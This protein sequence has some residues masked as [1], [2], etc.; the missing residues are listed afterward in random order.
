[1]EL[2]VTEPVDKDKPVA[3]ERVVKLKLGNEERRRFAP[4]LDDLV[5]GPITVELSRVDDQR[6]A[7]VIDLSSATLTVPWI[8]WAKGQGIGAKA[9]FEAVESE[10]QTSI[11]KFVLDGDGFGAAGPGGRQA[12]PRLG[13]SEADASCARRR[14]FAGR[15]SEQGRL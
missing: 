10:G 12:G 6:Q 3:R 2:Q 13:R 11:E 5:D 4:G 7:A 1:M 9:T 14:L 8:G 15:P